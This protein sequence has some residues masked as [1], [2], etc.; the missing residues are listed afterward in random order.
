MTLRTT[1]RQCFGSAGCNVTVEPRL[2]Y[3]G[4]SDGLDPD[5]VYEITYEISGDESGPVIE[6]AELSEQTSLNYSQTMLSTASSG[7]KVS[8][9]ITDITTQGQ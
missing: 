6:T 3:D 4:L 5:A 7:S 2:S 1:E 8:V 9:K